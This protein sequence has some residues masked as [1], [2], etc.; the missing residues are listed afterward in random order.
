M[1]RRM[2]TEAEYSNEWF[3]SVFNLLPF[4]SKSIYYCSTYDTRVGWYKFS[5]LTA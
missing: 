5:P 1:H 4:G 3:G 2:H